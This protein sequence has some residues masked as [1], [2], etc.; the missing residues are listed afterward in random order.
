M[1]VARTSLAR[2]VVGA[3]SWADDEIAR[4]EYRTFRKGALDITALQKNHEAGVLMPMLRLDKTRRRVDDPHAFQWSRRHSTK[5]AF[6]D[7]EP[8]RLR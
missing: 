1:R 3:P 8:I 7:G 4:P 2:A 6:A 5:Q